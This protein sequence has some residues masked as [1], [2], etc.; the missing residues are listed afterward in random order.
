MIISKWKIEEVQTIGSDGAT[1]SVFYVFRSLPFFRRKY[2]DK[3]NKL[4]IGKFKHKV[5]YAS[6]KSAQKR[7]EELN[8]K[9]TVT[10]KKII[11]DR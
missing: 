11:H 10:I 4:C 6:L 5:T 3:P 1:S 7:I 9:E 2:D 8:K